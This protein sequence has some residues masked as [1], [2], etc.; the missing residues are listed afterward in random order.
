MQKLFAW[1][2][3]FQQITGGVDFR[4]NATGLFLDPAFS[5]RSMCLHIVFWIYS[6][7]QA[8]TVC[9]SI[10][11]VFTVCRQVYAIFVFAIF[12]IVCILYQYTT[13]F[14]SGMANSCH[15]FRIGYSIAYPFLKVH[16]DFIAFAI[17]SVLWSLRHYVLHVAWYVDRHID[18]HI[19]RYIDRHIDW[20]ID[21]YVDISIDM[22]I[23]RSIC[24]STY[25]SIDPPRRYVK[26]GPWCIP[27]TAYRINGRHICF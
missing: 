21:R 22:S 4:N 18:R 19:D 17:L 12:Y 15:V 9:Q 24:R 11:K 10:L 16:L 14:H 5:L 20:Y 6:I 23:Y 13:S 2:F 8:V 1:T 7:L 26:R 3:V 27:E 25:R